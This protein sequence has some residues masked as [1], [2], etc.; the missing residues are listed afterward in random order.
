MIAYILLTLFLPTLPMME[1]PHRESSIAFL[2]SVQLPSGAFS[3]KNH[4]VDKTAVPS[5]RATRTGIKAFMLYGSQ[6]PNQDKILQFVKDCHSEK[7]GGF[8]DRPGIAPD[9]ISTS[10]ALMIL[11]EL[12]QPVEP[13]LKPALAY[14]NENT[15]TFEEIR[16]VAPSFEQL[17]LK[18][19]AAEAWG[20]IIDE[21]RN[22][23]GSYGKGPGM[24]RTTALRLVARQRLR[25]PVP[26]K[27]SILAIIRQG[28][29]EDGGFGS[30]QPGGS[31]LESC[32]R[33]VRLFSRLGSEPDKPAA[34]RAFIESCHHQSG[35]FGV[36]P[37]EA[38]SLHGTYYA[39]I[40]TSWLDGK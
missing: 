28:Q 2:K 24:V 35:G 34:V 9:P 3:V 33:I 13:Y 10:V 30:D 4:L 17:D 31:D 29:L 16:M 19:P 15:K 32:Y 7:T 20:K 23:D 18:S 1:P 36:K 27:E 8:S 11:K 14:M 40:V 37:G 25:L 12:N 39:A 6:A 22:P 5:I 26:A 38:P 21:A